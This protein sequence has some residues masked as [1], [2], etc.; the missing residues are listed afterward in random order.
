MNT[1]QNRTVYDFSLPFEDRSQFKTTL[2]SHGVFLENS[3]HK[4]PF[5]VQLQ[6]EQVFKG[7]VT[8]QIIDIYGID[9]FPV[10][11]FNGYWFD[12]EIDDEVLLY[13][14][15]PSDK[16]FGTTCQMNDVYKVISLQGTI[17]GWNEDDFIPDIYPGDIKEIPQLKTQQPYISNSLW[18]TNEMPA[19]QLGFE[20]MARLH[21]GP[22]ICVKI[23]S[24]QD[25]IQ[26]GFAKLVPPNENHYD[27][28]KYIYEKGSLDLKSDS[29]KWYLGFHEYQKYGEARITR[30]EDVIIKNTIVSGINKLDS[31]FD[32]AKKYLKINRNVS[33]ETFWEAGPRTHGINDLPTYEVQIS[34]IWSNNDAKPFEEI[35]KQIPIIK[36][37]TIPTTDGG[38]QCTDSLQCDG[39]CK[40][41]IYDRDHSTS[42]YRC[43]L[44]FPTNN[45]CFADVGVCSDYY[46]KNCNPELINGT[47]QGRGCY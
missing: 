2:T 26:R 14:H 46:F 28:S 39:H 8:K 6:V 37:V 42:D 38:T 19:C 5:K 41:I 36:H 11:S 9:G 12:P 40:P 1:H 23:E 7:N 31:R 32:E 15:N 17:W 29:T 4:A 13:L 24:V 47:L 10:Q 18:V 21:Y 33:Q 43:G 34:G 35:F 27:E 22:P 20:S 45:S 30:S 25:L 44:A 3:V 16:T